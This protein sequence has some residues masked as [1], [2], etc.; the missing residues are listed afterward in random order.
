MLAI[1]EA[2]TPLQW[3][4]ATLPADSSFQA[5]FAVIVRLAEPVN[6][7]VEGGAPGTS[8]IVTTS[9]QHANLPTNEDRKLYLPVVQR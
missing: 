2:T 8:A 3:Q 4:V 7:V 5:S 1:A 6:V 9:L